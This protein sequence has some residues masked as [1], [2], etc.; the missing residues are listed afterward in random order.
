M[1]FRN[2]DKKKNKKKKECLSR[3]TQEFDIVLP[4]LVY[5]VAE[6]VN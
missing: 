3:K 6:T 2:G 1:K 5:N 4:K